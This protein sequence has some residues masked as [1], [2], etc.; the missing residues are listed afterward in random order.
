MWIFRSKYNTLRP[1]SKIHICFH[2][3]LYVFFEVNRKLVQ[4]SNDKVLERTTLLFRR[5]RGR[6]MQAFVVTLTSALFNTVLDGH[7]A[8][9]SEQLSNVSKHEPFHTD[10]RCTIIKKK[11]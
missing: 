2:D 4:T 9:T 3:C 5:L 7:D 11:V 10:H 6:Q 1:Y 8:T